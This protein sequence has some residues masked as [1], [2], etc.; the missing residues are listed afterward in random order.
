M[1]NSRAS[2]AFD[3]SEQLREAII[4]FVD[5][6]QPSEWKIAFSHWVERV[7]LVLKNNGDDDSE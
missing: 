7:R 5:E 6:M 3:K 1:K 4:E 2:L